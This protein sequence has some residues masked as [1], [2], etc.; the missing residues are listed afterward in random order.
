MAYILTARTDFFRILLGV[1]QPFDISLMRSAID[2]I[3]H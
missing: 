2:L 1:F 3:K